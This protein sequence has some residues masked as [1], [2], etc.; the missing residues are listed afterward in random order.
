[1]QLLAVERHAAVKRLN[2]QHSAAETASKDA[3]RRLNRAVAAMK[4]FS[5]ALFDAED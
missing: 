5:E 2:R 3:K 4:S 1:M